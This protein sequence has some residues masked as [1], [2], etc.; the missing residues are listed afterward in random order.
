MA[1]GDAQFDVLA[2]IRSRDDMWQRCHV[3]GTS[4]QSA[5]HEVGQVDRNALVG[6]RFVL[7]I[8]NAQQQ[9]AA[10]CMG[11]GD[12][13]LDDFVPISSLS[14]DGTQGFLVEELPFKTPIYGF[15]S[16]FS[17]GWFALAHLIRW[18]VRSLDPAGRR[19]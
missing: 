10:R 19:S 17:D 8:F 18:Q 9:A 14:G 11:K 6:R 3:D 4:G 15:L 7:A 1:R 5:T 16:L 12:A 13:I 2:A